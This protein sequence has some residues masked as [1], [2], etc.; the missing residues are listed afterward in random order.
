M[1]TLRDDFM[2]GNSTSSMQ[3]DGAQH[4]GG[5][6]PSVYEHFDGAWEEAVDGYHRY[7]E[8][9]AL[10]KDMGMN[11]YRFQTSWSR[12]MPHG[13]GEINEE[14]LKYYS[15]TVD[16]LLAQGIEPMVCLYHF[17]MPLELAEKYHGF[18]SKEVV[19]AFVEYAKVVIDTLAP[20]VKWWVP[21]NE[22]NAFGSTLGPLIAGDLRPEAADDENE[23]F[24]VLHNSLVALARVERYL[25]EH[26]PESKVGCMAAFTP[27][28]PA[29]NDPVDVHAAHEAERFSDW[30]YYDVCTHGAYPAY[31]KSYVSAHNLSVDITEQELADLANA[32]YDFASLSYYRS[33]SV[34][35]AQAG[36]V[37][38]T[39]IIEAG[40]VRNEHL[41]ANEWNWEIDPLGFRY[42]LTEIHQRTGLPV[43]SLENGIGWRESLPADGSEIQDDY[44]IDYH[45]AHIRA[46]KDAVAFDGVDVLGYLGWGLIDIPSSSG[47][48][49]KRYGNV[50]V[51]Y[52]G[53]GEKH[54]ARYPKKSYAWI[55]RAFESNGEEL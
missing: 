48:T 44:R 21:F 45:R 47:D 36:N 16:E 32:R 29:S 10:M 51:D 12:V 9:I 8:D 34:S 42:S 1:A 11:C 52:A 7:R 46:M 24:Q 3:Y 49:E 18:A 13:V 41:K 38:V 6:G 19:D 54:L 53:A 55:K 30:L 31:F 26:Y 33:Q 28:Y 15:D 17:D 27:V 50:F 4:E 40:G 2:W 20:R 39:K 35:G 37:P 23:I 22:Q 5:K 43:F 14:G 25:H